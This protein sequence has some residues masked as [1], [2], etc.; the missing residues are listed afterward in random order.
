MNV[1]NSI[2]FA[3]L[4]SLA[5]AG[6]LQADEP[7]KV[8]PQQQPIPQVQPATP[9][10]TQWVEPSRRERRLQQRQGISS[11]PLV[12][13]QPTPTSQQ[14]VTQ[15]PQ[16]AAPPA[17]RLQPTPA[18]QATYVEARKPG[19]LGRLFGRR[20]TSYASIPSTAVITQPTK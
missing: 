4:T 3:S 1:R 19:P 8:Q 11:Q 17:A 16:A 7:I 18:V 20:S 5:V 12:Q 13:A 10:A 15:Q 6:A 2:A 14:A 9:P